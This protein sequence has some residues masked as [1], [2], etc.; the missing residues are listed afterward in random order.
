M[1][2]RVEELRAKSICAERNPL[3]YLLLFCLLMRKNSLVVSMG[4][5]EREREKKKKY[6]E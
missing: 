1:K 6:R 2:Y 3:T 4:F 5:K